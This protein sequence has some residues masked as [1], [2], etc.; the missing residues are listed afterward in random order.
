MN[1]QCGDCQLCCKL[2]P[3]KAGTNKDHTEV[4]AM[5]GN[6]PTIPDFYKAAGDRCQH[7]QHHKGCRVYDRRPVGCRVWSCRWLV[8][9]DTDK[10][11]RPDRSHFV[12]DILPDFV[13]AEQ[14]GRDPIRIQVVQVWLDPDY[15]GAIDDPELRAYIMRRGA[16]DLATLVRLDAHR[17][18]TILPPS[19]TGDREWHIVG[20]QSAL[21]QWESWPAH[22][23]PPAA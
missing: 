3:M 5:I 12:I 17:A 10:M 23:R 22:L 9:D 14:P 16:E 19:L 7:Q 6:P 4:R 13:V 8:G 20:G 15:P 21:K 18:V 2:L 1:R 11:S